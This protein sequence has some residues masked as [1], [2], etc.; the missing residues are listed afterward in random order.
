MTKS[1]W[2]I[3]AETPWW[4]Y[5]FVFGFF[6]IGFAATKPKV[7][8]LR[9]IFP[10]PILYL[11]LSFVCIYVGIHS[12]IS[13]WCYW[14]GSCVLG[15]A[16]GWLQMMAR[17]VKAIK[18]SDQLYLPGSWVLFFIVIAL[19]VLKYYLNYQFSYL[20]LDILS[21]PKNAEIFMALFGFCAGLYLGQIAYA[22]RTIKVGPYIYI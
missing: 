4:F 20:T 10:L 13:N 11:A 7:V 5:P 9:Q 1:V 21:D 17:R 14:L 12:T 8:H 6:Y 19:V 15:T 16:L 3:I 2:D 18:N 22:V